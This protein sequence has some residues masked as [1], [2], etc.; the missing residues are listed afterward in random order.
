MKICFFCDLHLPTVKGAL[1]Y[2][3]LE[4]AISDMKERG[5]DLAVYAGDV[6]S[7]GNKDVYLYFLERMNES[8]LDYLYIP[9]NSDVRDE[10]Y[11]RELSLL[12]SDIL[13]ECGEIKIYAVNDSTGSVD[14]RAFSLLGEASSD[15]IM[16]M[17][18]PI[19]SHTKE[20][21]A[22]LAEFKQKHPQTK[23]F[24]GHAH[25]RY[26]RG[27]EVSLQALDPDKA[28]GECPCITYYDTDT[29]KC[30]Y[31]YYSCPVPR[32]IYGYIGISAYRPEE[33][34]RFATERG[35][36]YLELRPNIA[37]M[38]DG[39]LVA[40]INEWRA[41]GGEHLSIHLPDVGWGEGGAVLG[42]SLD[43]LIYLAELLGADRFT[44]HV[45]RV[46]LCT[47][48]ENEKCL[49]T[50][51]AELA[52]KL[53][54]IKRKVAVGVENM[55]MT[56]GESADGRRRFGYTPPECIEFMKELAKHTHHD[57]G[58]NL[59]VGHARNNAPFSQTYQVGAWYSEVG[60]YTVGYHIHQVKWGMEKFSNHTAI[61]DVYGSLISYASFFRMW[62]EGRMNKAPFVFE[63]DE[64]DAYSVT[65]DTFDR[66]KNK[67]G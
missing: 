33:H 55:H 44:Q 4:W 35:I 32:D 19:G 62:S 42:S 10:R 12:S 46:P 23:M 41:S 5:C 40:L 22:R 24:F 52:K 58:I 45:P 13:N 59:D 1:Q 15:D 7:D 37:S 21:D 8:G 64:K 63:M 20:T 66:E 57:V 16:F 56:A 53:N 30:E 3:A 25:L 11:A 29:K 36:R 65:L 9:G 2:D 67:H 60:K 26:E 43:R 14:E 38:A 51:A 34:I 17:H 6:T 31:I 61:R 28:I 39:E 50:I 48:R 54:S 49:Y 27:N 47:V 18:H